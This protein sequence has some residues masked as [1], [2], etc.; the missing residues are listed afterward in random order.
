MFA[1]QR[2][3]WHIRRR[4]QHLPPQSNAGDRPTSAPVVTAW[5]VPVYR[6]VNLPVGTALAG[7]WAD[8]DMYIGAEFRIDVS[9]EAGS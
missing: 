5:G 4:G 8:C 7:A 2:A 6:D 9:S 3:R 1:E